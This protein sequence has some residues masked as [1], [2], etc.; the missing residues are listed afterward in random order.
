[1]SNLQR[2]RVYPSRKN[3][4]ERERARERERHGARERVTQRAAA[5]ARK[6]KLHMTGHRKWS[7]TN[8]VKD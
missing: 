8:H 7:V 6:I 4:R 5:G 2:V 3:K 1:M